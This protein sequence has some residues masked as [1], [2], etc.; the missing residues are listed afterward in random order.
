[1]KK[2]TLIIALALA[3]AVP[4]L[5]APAKHNPNQD[6]TGTPVTVETTASEVKITITNIADRGLPD[7]TIW[8]NGVRVASYSEI[9]KGKT[10]THTIGVNTNLVG[11]QTF[12]IVVW[13]RKGNKNFEDILLEETAVVNVK[14]YVSFRANGGLFSSGL[15]YTGWEAYSW[16]EVIAF[17]EEPVRDGY[18]FVGWTTQWNDALLNPGITYE[19][20]VG[21]NNTMTSESIWA[22]WEPIPPP[23]GP[24][25]ETIRAAINAALNGG[26]IQ[27]IVVPYNGG[28][29]IIL[30]IDGEEYIF[31]SNGAVNSDKSLVINGVRY[32]INVRGNGTFDVIASP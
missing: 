6:F 30:T 19:E 11:I 23:P 9:G 25:V 3:V 13:T 31:A 1:M 21:G 24:T 12:D 5:A 18:I 16:N 27:N 2:K 14:G 17:P 15:D 20:L 8:S 4:A 26:P 29:A 22:K 32:T 10:V 7:V 28:T